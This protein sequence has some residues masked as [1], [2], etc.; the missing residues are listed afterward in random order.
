[1][2]PP[3]MSPSL[4]LV[5]H[6]RTVANAQ[7]RLLGRGDPPLDELGRRQAE[8][9]AAALTEGRFGPIAAVVSSPLQRTRQTAAALGRDVRIDERFIELDYGDWEGRPVADVEPETWR[10]WQAD[11]DFAPP[12]GESLS[13]LS[14][15]VRNACVELSEEAVDGSIVV[16]SH[17]SPI[18]SAV[19]WG[20]GVTPSVS[21]RTHL[22]PA[23]ISR[24]QLRAARPT[25]DLFNETAHLR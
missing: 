1:M 25:L 18:K 8:A 9:V 7:G 17:V 12:G 4:I 16:V 20:L 6:G 3:Q 14:E 24:V 15:R 21:W 10:R 2:S 23:S 5:R 11:L 22:D 19:S 13:T